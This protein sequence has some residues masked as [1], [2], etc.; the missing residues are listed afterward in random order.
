MAC[1]LGQHLVP[2]CALLGETCGGRRSGPGRG[3]C[4]WAAPREAEHRHCRARW[5][6]PLGRWGHWT[7]NSARTGRW[8][9]PAA[10]RTA[11]STTRTGPR[12]KMWSTWLWGRQAGQV[13]P[14]TARCQP[15][16]EGPHRRAPQVH[17]SGQHSRPLAQGRV[18]GAGQFG[19]VHRR[20]IGE[21]GHVGAHHPQRTAAERQGQGGPAHPVPPHVAEVDDLVVF[22]RD[23]A[24]H[25]Q[26]PAPRFGL[27]V[28]PAGGHRLR[29]GPF[30]VEV[31][32]VA[33]PR[34][35]H[36]A[37]PTVVGFGGGPR[38]A[39]RGPVH[40]RRRRSP[41]PNRRPWRRPGPRRATS[42]LGAPARRRRCCGRPP[43]RRKDDPTRRCRRGG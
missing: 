11:P 36:R 43:P 40:A 7:L 27:A 18:E 38:P 26:A 31:E 20:A 35:R 37:H 8:S 32:G 29:E 23:P 41:V 15:G 13:R 2:W 9:E 1:E 19:E 4:S 39:D 28:A 3:R 33:R 25:G 10:A 42:T 22:D 24:E 14:L 30:A 34:P 16:Q 12:T 21:M 17:V 5:S 6:E